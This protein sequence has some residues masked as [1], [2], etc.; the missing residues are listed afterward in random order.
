VERFFGKLGLSFIFILGIGLVFPSLAR[1]QSNPS[2]RSLASQRGFVIGAG[3]TDPT[4]INDSTYASLAATQYNAIEP[5]NVMKMNALE[6]SQ[7]SFSFASADTVAAFAQANGQTLTATAPIWDGNPALDYGGSDPTWLLNGS[8]SSAEL[9]DILQTYIT[10]IM[11][12]YHNNYPGVVNRW[13]VVSEAVHLCRVFC[14]GLGNDADG[15]P[16]YVSLAYKYARAA[17]PT[18]QL[19]YDDWGGEGINS[20][21]ATS[22]YNLVSHLKSQGLV[23]CVGF[24]G[25]WEGGPISAIPSTTSIVSNINRYGALGL[26]VYFSQVEVGIPSANGSTANSSSDETAQGTEYGSLLSACLSTSACTAFYS[27]GITDKYA[28]CFTQGYCAPLPY[29]V[30]YNPKP[31]FYALQSALSSSSATSSAKPHPPGQLTATVQ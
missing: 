4:Q 1:P 8:F 15:F 21:Y 22:I 25:Q 18:A 12:H 10:T 3:A 31:A 20:T 29:D 14:Q 27:W 23:D 9:Q 16:A 26:S 11:Q 13:A 24:E 5:G 19:C 2:L 17:D 28:F 6:P 30:D 7:G